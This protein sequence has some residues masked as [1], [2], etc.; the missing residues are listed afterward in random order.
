MSATEGTVVPV[1]AQEFASMQVGVLLFCDVLFPQIS[2]AIVESVV[3][4]IVDVVVVG[5]LQLAQITKR[6]GVCG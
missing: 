6:S 5:F 2:R 3:V 4:E 1:L